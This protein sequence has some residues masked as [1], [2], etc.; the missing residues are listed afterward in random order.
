MG[1]GN[2]DTSGKYDIGIYVRESRDENEENYDTIE[3]QRDLL[4]DY[5][6]KLDIGKVREIYLDDNV[7]GSAFDRAG[8]DK[9]K[10]DVE[11]GRINLVLLKDLSRLGRNNAKTL[12]FLDYLEEY[13]VRILTFDGRYDS[14]NDNDTVGIETWA[15]E[16]YIRDISRKIRASLKYKI[17]KGDYIGNAPFGYK[18]S[19]VEKNRLYVDEENSETVR[20]IFRL[21]RMGYG[22]SSIARILNE[23][24]C[25][26]PG[27]GNAWSNI[28]V[29]RITCNRVYTGDTVQGVSEKISFKSKKT[30]RLPAANWIIT[31]NTHEAIISREEFSEV[32]KL[33]ELRKKRMAPHKGKL[34][35]FRDIL[36]CG[37]CASRMYARNKK[38]GQTFYICSKYYK[39]GR[40]ACSSH[41]VYEREM[42]DTVMAEIRKLVQ[43]TTAVKGFRQLADL[44][45][46]LKDD[47]NERLLKLE[48]NLKQK[49][50]QQEILYTDRLEE[51]ITQ[52][53]FV[54][55]NRQLDE[56][57]SVLRGEV[58]ILVSSPQVRHDAD[59]LISR[60]LAE[61]EKSGPTNE[62]V[63]C[64][65]RKITVYDRGDPLEGSLFSILKHQMAGNEN[66]LIVIDFIV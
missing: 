13:G 18:K 20:L 28:A 19:T 40:K 32:Q 53:L 44:D 25:Q 51:R 12:L 62:M 66:G 9:L 1:E 49:L 42:L 39:Y 36:V 24:G 45:G 55:M 3:T 34:H 10:E 52:N 29:R 43:D 48:T 31:A 64:L 23:R 63:K 27:G 61:L 26:A 59:A 47:H 11:R 4:V 50:K 14:L 65:V 35:V 16:R 41:L 56:R 46:M 8:L 2:T 22:Y 17:S 21:Y 30:R 58:E 5:A 7:S 38:N 54:K 6:G 60:M 15:N 57:I 33:R 37:S